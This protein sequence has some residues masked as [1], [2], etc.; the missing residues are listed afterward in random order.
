MKRLKPIIKK[1][2]SRGS[3]YKYLKYPEVPL[4]FND[5]YIITKGEDRLDLLAEQF[6]KDISLWWIIAIA[7]P[8][9]IKRDSFF[10]PIGVQL[11]IPSDTQSVI[12]DFNRIN[13]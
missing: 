2:S 9:I 12:D 11:R 10:V 5:I 6:Y 7:N 1:I 13:K 8:G 3:Y 4:S